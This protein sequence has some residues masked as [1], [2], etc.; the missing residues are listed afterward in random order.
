MFE[1][2]IENIPLPL[3][4]LHNCESRNHKHGRQKQPAHLGHMRGNVE[5]CEEVIHVIRVEV[6]NC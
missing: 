3:R 5:A 1:G 4:V 6:L 2:L